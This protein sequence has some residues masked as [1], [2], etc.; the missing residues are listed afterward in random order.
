M[1]VCNNLL[2]ELPQN[3]GSL[4]SLNAL[5]LSNNKLTFLP[6]TIKYLRLRFLNIADN[7]FAEYKNEINNNIQ[8]LSLEELAAKVVLRFRFAAFIFSYFYYVCNLIYKVIIIIYFY[9]L[10]K[11]LRLPNILNKYLDDTKYCYVCRNACFGSYIRKVHNF[12]PDII[13]LEYQWTLNQSKIE[14]YFCS[15]KCFYAKNM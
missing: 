6:G 9:R 1:S 12:Q 2:T 5:F 7:L 10:Q 3:I 4:Q 15:N 13:A 14:C 11:E 8:W